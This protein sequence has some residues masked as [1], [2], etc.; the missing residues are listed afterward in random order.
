[1]TIRWKPRKT[2]REKLEKDQQ[3]KVVDTPPR[4]QKAFGAGKMLIPTPALIDA[5]MKKPPAGKLVTVNQ[6]RERLAADFNVDSTCT[7]TTGMFVR[8]AAEAAEE[9]M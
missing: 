7:L 6:I 1:M 9:Y 4:M 2:W 8:I 5:L 3:P